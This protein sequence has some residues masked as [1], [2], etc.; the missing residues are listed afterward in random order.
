MVDT[1]P[2]D[3]NGAVPPLG[4]SV[5]YG[6]VQ[7][8]L[9]D[10]ASGTGPVPVAPLGVDEPSSSNLG[11]GILAGVGLGLVAVAVYVG[12]S[13]ALNRELLYFALLIGILV[14]F[15]ITRAG[16][17]RGVLAGVISALI[18]AVLF[19]LAVL[20]LFT[21]LLAKNYGEPFFELLSVVFD[22]TLE[23]LQMYF[24][25]PL[26]YV[27]GAATVVVGFMSGFAGKKV[28]PANA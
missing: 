5:Q 3:L 13:A 21:A 1:P 15:G 7:P 6:A 9:T 12:I 11:L 8:G 17:T 10:M 26:G 23:T 19:V 4:G 27:W 2:G 24:E 22:H 18:T 14:G 28:A 20:L 25:D 16:K